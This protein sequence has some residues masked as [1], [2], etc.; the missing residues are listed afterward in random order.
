MW[1]IESVQDILSGNLGK[2]HFQSDKLL[3]LKQLDPATSQQHTDTGMAW[4]ALS[5]EPRLQL[6]ISIW[7]YR[8]STSEQHIAGMAW[9]TIGWT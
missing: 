5:S 1:K 7:C 3:I 2:S 8:S 4:S 9:C 6:G